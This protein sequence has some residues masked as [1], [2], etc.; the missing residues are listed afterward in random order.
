MLN[1]IVKE[2]KNNVRNIYEAFLNYQCLYRDIFTQVLS[3]GLRK[4]LLHCNRTIQWNTQ[5]N[6]MSE[7]H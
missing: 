7:K 2:E 5:K 6:P 3:A 1:D 4:N